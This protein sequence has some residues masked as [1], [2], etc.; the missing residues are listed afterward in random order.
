MCL[1]SAC[2]VVVHVSFLQLSPTCGLCVAWPLASMTWMP[3]GLGRGLVVIRENVRCRG[4]AAWEAGNLALDVVAR[5][6]PSWSPSERTEGI[7]SMGQRRLAAPPCL[8]AAAADRAAVLPAAAPCR[9]RRSQHHGAGSLQGKGTQQGL[10]ARCGR[11]WVSQAC[12]R[13]ACGRGG[14]C[15]R[16]WTTLANLRRVANPIIDCIRLGCAVRQGRVAVPLPVSCGGRPR[17]CSPCGGAVPWR[18]RLPA[19][20]GAAASAHWCRVA[21]P[22][23]RL[24]L[25]SLRPCPPAWRLRCSLLP[26]RPW[27]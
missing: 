1:P 15:R 8:S 16:P 7:S 3:R 19:A 5:P 6:H 20:Q 27:R 24:R 25:R 18:P 9:G 26:R 14:C 12:W 4:L 11:S 23:H 17:R 13:P 22:I 10:P 2:S 21:A